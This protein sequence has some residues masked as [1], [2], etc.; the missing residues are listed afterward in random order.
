MVMLESDRR[1]FGYTGVPTFV[2]DPL[3]SPL[4]LRLYYAGYG[5]LHADGRGGLLLEMGHPLHM[6]SGL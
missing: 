4:S 5:V 2:R 1:M 6:Q 3:S